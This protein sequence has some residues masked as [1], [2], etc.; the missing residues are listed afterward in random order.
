MAKIKRKMK[1]IKIDNIIYYD[2][3]KETR[4]KEIEQLDREITKI[5]NKLSLNPNMELNKEEE[6]IIE[7]K[8]K[9]YQ[10]LISEEMKWSDIIYE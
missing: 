9:R 3:Q 7:D 10:N 8:T 4:R 6:E 1:T 5:M 2:F